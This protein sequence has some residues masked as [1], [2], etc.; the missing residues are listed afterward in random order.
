MMPQLGEGSRAVATGTSSTI[1]AAPAPNKAH[2]QTA[3]VGAGK[4]SR[5]SENTPG[6]GAG[7]DEPVVRNAVQRAT[8]T[9]TGNDASRKT[10]VRLVAKDRSSR[11]TAA[12]APKR[13]HCHNANRGPGAHN[14]RRPQT[15]F[16][17][18]THKL[19]VQKPTPT[20]TG[21]DAKRRPFVM[22]RLIQ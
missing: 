19:A 4:Y 18:S 12:P 8:P 15:S 6:G 20:P 7:Q 13:A 14:K 21:T 10:S 17:V 16:A 11:T 9:P 2:N 22:T 5:H 3:K 1:T